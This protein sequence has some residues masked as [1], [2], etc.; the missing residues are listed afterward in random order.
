[1]STSQSIHGLLAPSE[2]KEKSLGEISVDALFGQLPPI[3]PA[4]FP[5]TWSHEASGFSDALTSLNE[6]SDISRTQLNTSSLPAL[7]A[8]EAGLAGM[9]AGLGALLAPE[10]CELGN[11]PS[12]QLTRS[13][14]H[15]DPD[16]VEAA[17]EPHLSPNSSNFADLWLNSD[18]SEWIGPDLLPIGH[19]RKKPVAPLSVALSQRASPLKRIPKG[20]MNML[21][22]LAMLCKCFKPL[23]K[24]Y[25]TGM[26][27]E[28][29]EEGDEQLLGNPD[30]MVLPFSPLAPFETEEATPLK[31]R[32]LKKRG[33][34]WRRKAKLDARS[35][36]GEGDDA[37]DDED[38]T[39]GS[40]FDYDNF[41]VFGF[42][43]KLLAKNSS[44][45]DGSSSPHTE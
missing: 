14:I 9:H 28:L 25:V 35:S 11:V 42:F 21:S 18:F 36:S 2:L 37:R 15:R 3:P 22:L 19:S 29:L 16:S 32:D 41:D 4:P 17:F 20:S 30:V 45:Q 6:A 1:M 23:T 43:D 12:T 8:M 31:K 34:R 24:R 7:P 44:S 40:V 39:E 27:G 10:E 38:S 5:S 33:K 13:V 26:R